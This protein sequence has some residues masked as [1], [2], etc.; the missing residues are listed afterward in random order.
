MS[1]A[2]PYVAGHVSKC[3]QLAMLL[4]I[5][6]Y[7]KP[8]NVHRTADFG[9]TKYEHFLASAVQL[10][11]YFEYAAE[12]GMRISNHESTLDKIEVGRVISEAMSDVMRSQHGG[13][14]SLGSIILLI[15]MAAAAGFTLADDRVFSITRFRKN[16][17]SVVET[18]TPL[19]AV[20]VYDAINVA[21]PGGMGKSP[22]L[23]VADSESKRKILAKGTSLLEVFKISSKWD[24]VAS[25]WVN[26]YHITFDIGYPYLKQTLGETQDINTTT[27]HTFLKILCDVPD[28]LI[29]RKLGKVKAQRVSI[30]AKRVLDAGGLT[31]QNGR[32]LLRKLD[33]ELHDAKH[34]LNPGTTADITSAVLAV[35]ILEGYRP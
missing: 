12:Q 4:E 32:R 20:N 11:P 17:R 10:G 34:R 3:L 22:R 16:L 23:D 8:G 31:T 15:P 2:S 28:T 18:S 21:N 24:S 6:A 9:E 7:P 5:S 19:D 27:V 1:G 14:T 13:N 25:E 33:R 26:G 30:K 29:A 35:A